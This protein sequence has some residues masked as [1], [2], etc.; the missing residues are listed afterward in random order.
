MGINL[1][2]CD[3]GVTEKFL[4]NAQI[5]AVFEKVCSE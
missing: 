1:G 2:G 3:I 4:N 5:G